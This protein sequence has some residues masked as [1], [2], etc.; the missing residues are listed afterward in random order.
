M[1]IIIKYIRLNFVSTLSAIL[2]NNAKHSFSVEWE[3]CEKIAVIFV[4]GL[5]A[6]K[7]TIILFNSYQFKENCESSV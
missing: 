6:F 7:N 1:Y 3:V 2:H 5:F 4:W